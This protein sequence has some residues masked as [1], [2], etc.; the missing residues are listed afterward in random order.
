MAFI[1]VKDGVMYEYAAKDAAPL[2]RVSSVGLQAYSYLERRWWWLTD[3]GGDTN[4]NSS[5]DYEDDFVFLNKHGFKY[6]TVMVAPWYGDNQGSLPWGAVVGTPEFEVVQGKQT[7]KKLGIRPEYFPMLGAML[8]KAAQYGLSVIFCPF[9]DVRAI[10]QMVEESVTDMITLSDSKS[11]LYMSAFLTALVTQFKHDTSVAGWMITEELMN[12]EELRPT[13]DPATFNYD[14]AGELLAEWAS[15]VRGADSELKRVLFACNNGMIHGA[16]KTMSLQYWA[17]VVIP[18]MNPFP[19]DT[20]SETLFFTNEYVSPGGDG[21]QAADKYTPPDYIS[22]S[23]GYLKLMQSTSL[24]QGK[25]YCVT[26]FGESTFQEAALGDTELKNLTAFM[27]NMARAGVQLSFYWVWNGGWTMKM[28]GW[29]TLVTDDESIAYRLNAFRALKGALQVAHSKPN[30]DPPI[31]F[32]STKPKFAKCLLIDRTGGKASTVTI[33]P[34]ALILGKAFTL[35]YTIQHAVAPT[36]SFMLMQKSKR[37]NLPDNGWTLITEGAVS[38]PG[39]PSYLT[40]APAG[41]APTSNAGHGEA[42]D[43]VGKWARITYT[44]SANGVIRLY[45]NDFLAMAGG[46]LIDEHYDDDGSTFMI[47]FGTGVSAGKFYLS[48]LIL[49]DR[50]LSAHEIFEYGEYGIVRQPVARWTF[51]GNA[52]NALPGGPGGTVNSAT[53]PTTPN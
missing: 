22:Q 8:K 12:L 50:V 41:Y 32:T 19:I 31:S 10:P 5:P 11:R 27:N 15:S 46:K 44:A 33:N 24:A 9:W 1:Q 40:V 35:S 29:E 48:D 17:E 7:I 42:S 34:P 30:A 52:D 45:I 3:A 18:K 43:P 47:G 14:A 49:Y 26:S 36:G 25:A 16:H 39:G 53:F 4:R 28:E 13:N 6:V 2:G 51:D 38:G 23:L 20:V 37:P 21:K